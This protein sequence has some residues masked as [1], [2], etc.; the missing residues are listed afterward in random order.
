MKTLSV[1]L[2][3]AGTI[4]FLF[5]LLAVLAFILVIFIIKRYRRCPSDK[6]LV[7][8]GKIGKEKGEKRAA[9]VI[10]GG[11][12]FIWPI[13]QDYEYIDL[14]PI[15]IIVDL[16]GALSKQNI[17]VNVPARFMVGISTEP[18][19]MENAAERLLGLSLQQ[20]HDLAADIIFGQLRVVIA[21]M[22]IEEINSDREKFLA[23]VT[24]AV[25]HELK[26]IGLKLINVNVTDI[27]DDNG[28]IEALGKEATSHAINEARKIVAEKERDGSI[29]EANAKQE[30]RVKV[31]EAN[32]QAVEGENLAQITI[33]RSESEKRIQMSLALKEAE[34]AEKTN[35]A[36]ARKASYLA[37]KEAE[38]ARAERENATQMANIIVPQKIEKEKIEIAAEAEAERLRRVAKGQADAK[39][40]E[41]DALARG[42]FEILSKQ[43]EGFKMIVNA[44]NGDAN[45]AVRL[46]IADKLEKLVAA[47]VEAIKNIKID[48]VTVWDSG[49]SDGKSSTANFIKNMASSIPPMQELF[50]M[51]GMN[52]PEYL[53]KMKEDEKNKVND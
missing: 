4:G 38:M 51:A 45:S 1:L 36:Q 31:A 7:V 23:N 49:S 26:K 42:T 9:K 14:T 29:G 28:Y 6:L 21:T 5:V 48:K 3:A 11:A 50:N 2:D 39:Y 12:A 25:E 24:D 16:K 41:M 43:A 32:A 17:R 18:G 22:K 30:Q 10:H 44:A 8:F 53:A 33:A 35:Q 13:I 20:I 15:P 40:A 52:L 27:T 19:I 37:E 47:Q 46:L 34:I